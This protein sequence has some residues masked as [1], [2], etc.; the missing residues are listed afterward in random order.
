VLAA[1]IFNMALPG[2]T[3]ADSPPPTETNTASQISNV[4]SFSIEEWLKKKKRN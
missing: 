3:R 1:L 4:D 2:L